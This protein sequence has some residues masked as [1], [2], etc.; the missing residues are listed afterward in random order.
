MKVGE[1]FR[2]LAEVTASQW[3]MVTTAQA[4]AL[5]VTRLT[6]SRLAEAGHL[7][8]LMH[9]VYKDAGAPGSEFDD[10]RAAWLSAEPKRLAEERVGSVV[11]GVVVASTSAAFLHG[12]GDSWAGRHQFVAPVRR[13]SQREDLRFRQR[14][15]AEQDVTLVQGLP[16]MRIERTLADLLED[17]G[18]QSLVADA[19]GDAIKKNSVDLD[20]LSELLSPLAE[21]NGLKKNDGVALLDKM[22]ESAGLDLD[23]VARRITTNPAL[24]ARVASDYLQK[25]LS[26]EQG[27]MLRNLM[28]DIK[29]PTP[30]ITTEI[31]EA[32]QQT[33]KPQF[34]A[35]SK[36]M[37][38]MESLGFTKFLADAVDMQA[39]TNLSQHWA[40]NSTFPSLL[41]DQ[42][43]LATSTDLEEE[44]NDEAE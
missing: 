25:L 4:S 42:S 1:V 15:L 21:R 26:V 8:R 28:A 7:E 36:L 9:G 17:L 32:V 27:I 23:S 19:L 33:M 16:A 41:E 30:V 20:R 44:D 5:G 12:V 3:G 34:D 6:L 37:P 14:V 31:A 43:K 11:N 35:I 13:Q 18:D 39:F 24:G 22:T 29:L 38:S 40:K 10:L 2:E